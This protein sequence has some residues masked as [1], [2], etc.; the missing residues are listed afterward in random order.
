MVDWCIFS[1]LNKTKSLRLSEAVLNANVNVNAHN[2]NVNM[3]T[4]SRYNAYH[5]HYLSLHLLI[6]TKLKVQLRLMGMSLYMYNIWFDLMMALDEKLRDHKSYYDSSWGGLNTSTKFHGSPT[7]SCCENV[8]LLV[9]PKD[10]SEAHQ[11]H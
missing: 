10:K 7:N 3:L 8:N 1:L 2:D 11:N 6:S 4:L 5:V 9:V